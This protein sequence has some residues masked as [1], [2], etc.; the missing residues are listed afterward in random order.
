MNSCGERERERK[1]REL[2]LRVVATKP[3]ILNLG[4]IADYIAKKQAIALLL[5]LG[6]L[7]IIIK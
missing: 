5:S 1:E 7:I 2:G 4:T 3:K 6:Q